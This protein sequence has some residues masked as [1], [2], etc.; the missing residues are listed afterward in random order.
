VLVQQSVFDSDRCLGGESFHQRLAFEMEDARIVM[1]VEQ[2]T[3][4]FARSG[5]DGDCEIA[6]GRMRTGCKR[7]ERAAR[8]EVR[9][10]GDVRATD[11]A[12]AEEC[13][14]E[15]VIDLRQGEVRRIFRR[16]SGYLD[17]RTGCAVSGVNGIEE[18]APLRVTQLSAR[19]E[20]GL[21]N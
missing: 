8:T 10:F 15:S 20:R 9:V 13:L 3:Q 5:V 18:R 16:R 1:S 19:V 6:A 21:H 14:N 12:I 7:G 4:Q 2:A 11:R 17:Q